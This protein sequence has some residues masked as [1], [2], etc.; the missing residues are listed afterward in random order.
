MTVKW[1]R[2]SFF[3]LIIVLLLIAGTYLLG[4]IYLLDPVKADYQNV[5]TDLQTQQ[6][7]L[8]NAD[9]WEEIVDTMSPEL[10]E[11]LPIKKQ[12]DAIINLLDQTKKASK[13][14]IRTVQVEEN[15]SETEG[16]GELI[17]LI[18]GQAATYDS[19][20]QFLTKLNKDSRLIDI[21]EINV[22]RSGEDQVID[23]AIQFH[24]FF[25]PDLQG[26]EA[27]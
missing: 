25:A 23:Y 5:S 24:T 22:D 8:S 17:Y 18:E 9:T 3:W 15:T 20:H 1:T 10:L 12:N 2:A 19:F 6:L 13:T 21:R 26:L 27:N 4:R 16:V 11:K 14:S 7:Y